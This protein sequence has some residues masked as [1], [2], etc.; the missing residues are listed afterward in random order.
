LREGKERNSHLVV[1][2]LGTVELIEGREG[3]LGIVDFGSQKV[4]R[5]W[6]G[7]FSFRF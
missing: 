3:R 5:D 2:F 4:S 1:E 6:F 7:V